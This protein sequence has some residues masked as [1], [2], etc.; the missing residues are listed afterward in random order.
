MCRQRSSLP[1]KGM[2]NFNQGCEG[3]IQT[4]EVPCLECVFTTP[5][6][7]AAI[8]VLV[9]SVFLHFPYMA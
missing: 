5:T 1:H 3:V 9:K 6:L 7:L 8:N 4:S 2:C